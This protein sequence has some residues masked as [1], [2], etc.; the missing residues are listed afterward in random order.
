MNALEKNSFTDSLPVFRSACVAPR[1]ILVV[2]AHWTTEGTW[3]TAMEQPRTIHDF[4]GFP[5]NL[6]A[7]NYPAPGSPEIARLIQETVHEPRVQPDST[8]WGLDHGAWALLCRIFPE[9]EIPVLQLSIDL[10][11]PAEEHF[12][13]GRQL[14]SLRDQGVLIIGSG[15]I[16]HNLR[17]I[18]WESNAD[19]YS[20]AA[21]FDAWVKERLEARDFD[22]LVYDFLRTEAGRLSVPTLEHYLPLLYVLGASDSGDA[23]SFPHEGIQNAS[24]AMRSFILG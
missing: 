21:E 19:P 4:H 15:N 14:R 22:A 6:F 24:I 8:Q 17:T 13:V 5:A 1:A 11:L 3:V 10:A 18:R 20:W 7:I 2:S 12:Q 23:L 9:A 16:V